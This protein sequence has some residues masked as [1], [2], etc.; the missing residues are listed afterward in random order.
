[1]ASMRAAAWIPPLAW[2]GVISLLSSDAGSAEHTGAL[3]RPLLEALWPTADPAQVQA[4]HGLIRKAAHFTEFGVLTLLW[5]RAFRDRPGRAPGSASLWALAASAGWALVDE[6]L[7]AFVVS[8]TA[9]ATDALIDITGAATASVI[10]ATGWRA[11]D[12][13]TRLLL[14]LAM[15]GGL[16]VLALHMALGVPGGWL[17]LTTP[18]A[19]VALVL[20][21]RPRRPAAATPSSGDRGY[22][23]DHR[24]RD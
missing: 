16:L 3:L 24:R 17:W 12:I 18:A 11:A 23:A 1:M 10:A 2:M 5:Y 7:Q 6:G 19:A 22:R 15:L 4:V 21:R 9:S 20:F 14:W 13:V 8:R